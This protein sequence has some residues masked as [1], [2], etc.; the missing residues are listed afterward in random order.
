MGRQ[1]MQKLFCLPRT[2]VEVEGVIL[3]N[4]NINTQTE[5]WAVYF[6]NVTDISIKKFHFW[7]QIQ[8]LA[9]TPLIIK[10]LILS[11]DYVLSDS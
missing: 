6:F 2:Y 3:E 1:N 5:T 4:K 9:G 11:L 8:I 7:S 10:F